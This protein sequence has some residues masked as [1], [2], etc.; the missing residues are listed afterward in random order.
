MRFDKKLVAS[1]PAAN[2]PD[3]GPRPGAC[4]NAVLGRGYTVADKGRLS[5]VSARPETRLVIYRFKGD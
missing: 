5:Q 3:Q 2:F 4:T 1:T